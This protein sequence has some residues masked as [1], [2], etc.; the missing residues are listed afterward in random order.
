MEVRADKT[1]R[2]P[3]LKRIAIA[4]VL[5]AIA[6]LALAEDFYV[7]QDP[8]SK[9]CKI[10]TEKPDGQT[11]IMIGTG[12]YPPE[13]RQRPPRR[14]PPSARRRKAQIKFG[15]EPGSANAGPDLFTR[16]GLGSFSSLTM[17]LRSPV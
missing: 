15:R 1:R 16:A 11:M 12:A 9:R 6:T 7:G 13:T 8:D 2:F 4:A 14:L 3:C 17:T 10:V 5:I